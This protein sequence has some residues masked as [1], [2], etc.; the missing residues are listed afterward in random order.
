MLKSL[1]INNFLIIEN[2]SVNFHDGLNVLTGETGAGKSILLEALGFALGFARKSN[3]IKPGNDR[4]EVSIELELNGKHPVS[5]LFAEAG[6]PVAK[7]L[8]IRRVVFRDGRK[9]AYVND[10]RV[11]ADF[12]RSVSTTLVEIHGQHD[13]RGIL[14]PKRHNFVLDEFA[15]LNTEKLEILWLELSE[16]KKYLKN[17]ENLFDD[18]LEEKEFIRHSYTQ[19]MELNLI[20]NE[21]IELDK[22]RKLLQQADRLR[23]ELNKITDLIGN[24]GAEGALSTAIRSLERIS[25]KVEGKLDLSILFLR[26]AMSELIEG[27]HGVSNF[28]TELSFSQADLEAIEDRLFEIRSIARKHNILPSNLINLRNELGSKLK[29]FESSSDEVGK[30]RIKINTL[31]EDYSKYA[32][33][34]SILRKDAAREL[35]SKINAELEPLRLAKANFKTEI[36]SKAPGLSGIDE[37][38]FTVSTSSG[39]PFGALNQI[40][41]GGELSRFV[42]ALKVCMSGK[43]KGSTMIFDEIDRGVGGGTAAAIGRR[44]RKISNGSQVIVVTHSPQVAAYGGH[45]L[46]VKKEVY[47]EKTSL[48]IFPLDHAARIEEIARMLS[49]DKLTLESREMAKVLLASV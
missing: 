43:K 18:V 24:D 6:L 23:G 35:D 1:D 17:I 41:S 12:L 11:S 19:I 38:A 42:L 3:L 32:N 13:D 25:E 10:K 15:N 47:A 2:L 21:D 27:S 49:G 8:L 48:N 14:N 44:L 22:K 28:L 30:L 9:Q 16:A 4:A 29:T 34:F 45:H 31:E 39:S 46:L 5:N 33:Q 20:P 37:I 36:R 40:A 7:E 26:R